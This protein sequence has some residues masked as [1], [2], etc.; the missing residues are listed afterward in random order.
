MGSIYVYKDDLVFYHHTITPNPRPDDFSMHAHDMCEILYLLSGVGRY[1][2][3]GSEYTIE[4]GGMMLMRPSETHKVQMQPDCVYE[5][6]AVH[7]SKKIIEQADPKGELLLPFEKRPL[8]QWNYYQRS[9]FKSGF[10][11]ECLNAMKTDSGDEYSRR[12]S[13]TSHLFP[14][15][16]EVRAAFGAR[17]GEKEESQYHDI[18]RELVDYINYNLMS[19]ELSLDS[20]SRYFLISKPHLN[21]IF[22]KATG[23]TIWNYVLI[24]RM[25]AARQMIMS[26][27]PAF[28]VCQACGFKDYSAF[29]RLYKKKFNLT[30][31]Q[32]R[33]N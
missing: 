5:R 30:P 18:S 15:L 9:S 27:K 20:L 3:E 25:M 8:G 6:I 16:I 7:F 14:V 21:R 11:L 19:A 4:P 2:V 1:I 33:R 23:S 10:V 17:Q 24:K 12:L 28:E 22:K 31:Q 29:Y 13:I 32:E 26:G